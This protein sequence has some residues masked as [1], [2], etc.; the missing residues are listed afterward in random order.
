VRGPAYPCTKSLIAV[1]MILTAPISAH[2]LVKAA[3]HLA[4]VDQG[5][6]SQGRRRSS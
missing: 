2:L 1:F 3:M 6:P 5:P 4:R